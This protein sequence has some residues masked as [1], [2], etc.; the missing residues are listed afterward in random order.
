LSVPLSYG[1][2]RSN[3]LEAGVL[4]ILDTFSIQSVYL[5]P[6]RASTSPTFQRVFKNEQPIRLAKCMHLAHDLN[7]NDY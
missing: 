5:D 7:L 1:G 3:V 2:H 4:Y 6:S